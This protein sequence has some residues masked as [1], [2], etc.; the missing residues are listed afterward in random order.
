M[1]DDIQPTNEDWRIILN[2]FLSVI[3]DL[4]EIINNSGMD[5]FEK[6]PLIET[7]ESIPSREQ[8]KAWERLY[9]GFYDRLE[10]MAKQQA[11]HRKELDALKQ[12]SQTS[13][14]S[15]ILRIFNVRFRFGR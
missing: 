10:T 8:F 15:E 9:P 1:K 13:I 2:D 12:K 11:N 4:V 3:N 7:L 14:F 5:S 6:Y